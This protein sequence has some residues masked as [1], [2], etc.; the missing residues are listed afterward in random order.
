MTRERLD[1]LNLAWRGCGVQLVNRPC[2]GGFLKP[3]IV[4]RSHDR[5]QPL[6]T[7]H[8]F[9]RIRDPSAL[10]HRIDDWMTRRHSR[11]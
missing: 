11:E 6:G 1:L 10:M 2:V 4:T 5:R 9:P 7:K 3:K 8:C